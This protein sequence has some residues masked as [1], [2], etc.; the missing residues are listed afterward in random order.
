MLLLIQLD[1]VHH[2]S[3]KSSA[4]VRFWREQWF[5]HTLEELRP[6]GP[7]RVEGFKDAKERLDKLNI[8]L[9]NNRDGNLWVM[10]GNEPSFADFVLGSHLW[11]WRLLLAKE[12]WDDVKTWHDGR[13]A[14]VVEALSSW[15][16]G[17]G[18]ESDIWAPA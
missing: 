5:G 18:D 11:F 12:E 4:H 9:N 6:A 1:I 10:G 3:E 15:E 17:I 14:R 16:D 2:L 8:M 7:K 13:W